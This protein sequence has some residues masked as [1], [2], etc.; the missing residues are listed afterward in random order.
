VGYGR[1]D[2]ILW[3]LSYCCSG[4]AAVRPLAAVQVAPDEGSE[5]LVCVSTGAGRSVQ[6]VQ[7]D[8]RQ[9]YSTDTGKA[10]C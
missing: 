5:S 4:A 9:G 3:G 8:V 1:I 10:E 6:P 7:Q 2:T